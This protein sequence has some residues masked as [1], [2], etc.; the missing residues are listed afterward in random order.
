[1]G[2]IFVTNSFDYEKNRLKV[3]IIK[4]EALKN[5]TYDYLV[6]D[7]GGHEA[8]II[9]KKFG[10]SWWRKATESDIRRASAV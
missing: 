3:D 8:V 6:Y 1:M 4:K 2:N 5:Y 9:P 10:K 7:A